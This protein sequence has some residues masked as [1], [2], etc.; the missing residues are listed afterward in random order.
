MGVACGTHGGEQ[1]C[2]LE[3]VLW[4]NLKEG[5]HLKDKGVDGSIILKWIVLA[6][7]WWKGVWIRLPKDRDRCWVVVDAVMNLRVTQNAGNS[8]NS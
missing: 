7:R 2:V 8:L 3:M 4:G 6:T 5:D 1:K